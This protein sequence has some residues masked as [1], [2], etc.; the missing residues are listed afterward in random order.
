M[1]A[2]ALRRSIAFE[3]AWRAEFA[4]NELAQRK[5]RRDRAANDRQ[6]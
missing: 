1:R 4:L 5:S 2:D 6:H 3:V